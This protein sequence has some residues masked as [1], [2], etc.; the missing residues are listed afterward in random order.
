MDG[1][2]EVHKRFQNAEDVTPDPRSNVA[3]F[4]KGGPGELQPRALQLLSLATWSGNIEPV[5]QRNY[6][7]KGWLGRGAQSVIYGP[8][9]VGKSF[10]AL[11]LA[12][13]VSQGTDWGGRRV[14][15]TRVL[16]IAAEGGASFQN[17]VA[18]LENP[19]FWVITA[20]L[21]LAGKGSQAQ[22]LAEVLAHLAS[23]G[24]TDFGLVIVDTMS[25]VMGSADENA[26]PDIA[27]LIHNLD[28]LRRATGAHVLLVHHTGKDAARGARGH[29]SLRAAIDTEIELSR[30]ET[31]IISAEVTKQRDGPTGYRFDY[32]L[33]QVELG[34]DQD[35]DA[36][37][38]CIVEQVE[39]ATGRW[40]SVPA[41]AQ[42]ALDVLS[43]LLIEKGEVKRRP[44]Y[45]SG[46]CVPVEVWR[47]ACAEPGRVSSSD[48]HENR[49]RV[50]RKCRDQLEAAKRVCIRDD[51]VWRVDP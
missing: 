1:I 51:L 23:V 11:D 29:S 5:L 16:Y 48:D 39:D 21:T 24:G 33:R 36:V 27:D 22:P 45:P 20:P 3:A 44:E 13:H 38:T 34:H 31:G 49:R 18:A 25:R 28:S 12:H 4:R 8:S 47:D 15:K 7:V 46:P 37:T 41:S 42:K 40:A 2:D 50:W 19:E 14:Q 9:N 17:R 26:A 30:D 10:L 43:E 6:L 35:G 32:T